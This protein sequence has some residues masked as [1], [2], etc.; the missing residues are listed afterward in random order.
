MVLRSLALAQF[1][2]RLTCSLPPAWKD[3]PSEASHF[4][5]RTPSFGGMYG[6]NG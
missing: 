2:G 5:A 4:T 3:P 6:V 1:R